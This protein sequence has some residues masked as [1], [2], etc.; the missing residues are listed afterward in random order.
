MAPRCNRRWLIA[1]RPVRRAV[2]PGDFAWDEAT[3]PPLKDGEVRVAVR[4]LSLDP[5]LKGKL[6]QIAGYH[7][8]FGAGD[9][10]PSAGIG[11]VVESAAPALP[12][13]ALV[14]GELGWQDH[15]TLAA[16]DVVVSPPV[17]PG[18][19]PTAVLGILGVTGL[20]A[21]F[22]L[23]DVGRPRPGETVVVSGAAGATGSVVGQIARI[24]GCHVIGIVGGADKQRWVT[25]GLGFDAAVDYRAEKVRDRLKALAPRGVDLFFD[26]VG[27]AVLDEVLSRIAPRARI[28]ICGAASQYQNDG[29]PRGP[30]NYMNL[31]F[32]RARMEGFILYDY[33][34]RFDEARAQLGAWL[35]QGKLVDREHV[36]QGLE[37][38]PAALIRQLGGAN[39]GKTLLKLD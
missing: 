21:Y 12:V 11:E 9:V 2:V 1:G 14:Q 15:A 16:D 7:T 19:S 17:P 23:L 3:C 35:E 24:T 34:D 20:T 18:I 37:N 25:S 10:V 8:E 38:A 33:A 6:E 27:G 39:I 4:W 32:R 26:N 29:P 36:E 30:A 22:G 13:G 31:V 28:V 5:G